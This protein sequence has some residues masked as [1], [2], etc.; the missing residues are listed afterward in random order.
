M[1]FI[2]NGTTILDNGAFSVNLGS[3]VLIKEQ[4]AS[5][6]STISFVDGSSGVVLDSTYPIYKFVFINIHPSTYSRF[7]FQADVNGGSSYNQTITS[8]KFNAY[9]QEH[10]GTSS[11]LDYQ[12]GGDQA[13][14]TSFQRLTN[15]IG[16]GAGYAD[17]DQAVNGY[18]KI[19]NPSSTTF[20]KHFIAQALNFD[21]YFSYDVYTAGYFNTTNALDR[22]QFKFS[23]GTMDSGTIKL[24]GIKDS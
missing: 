20:V 10:S 19:F 21:A 11:G 5:S 1:A 17:N 7:V 4:T 9:N 22:F 12:A 14:G 2:S 16:Y 6:S 8:T 13:Q 18:L 15:T 23:S 3:Q 24:Y